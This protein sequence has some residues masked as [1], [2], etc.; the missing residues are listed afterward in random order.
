MSRQDGAMSQIKI[1]KLTPEQE[2]LIPLYSEKWEKIALTTQPIDRQKASETIKEA[3]ALMGLSEPEIL[4]YD[5]PYEALQIIKRKHHQ[6]CPKQWS[7]LSSQLNRQLL[8]KL[9]TDLVSQLG[10][11]LEIQLSIQ[12]RQTFKNLLWMNFYTQLENYLSPQLGSNFLGLAF[13]ESIGSE[14]WA[15][16]AN[17]F[18]F[19]ISGLNCNHSEKDWGL[20]QAIVENTGWTFYYN[21]IAIVCNRPVKL[22]FD[23]EHRLHGIGEP[24]LQY[25]DGFHLYSYH[26]VTLPEKYGKLPPQQWQAQW[27]IEERN[28]EVRR[29]LIQEIGYGRI[30]QEL[31]AKTL[32]SWQEYTLLKIE[33]TDVEPIVLLKM[34]CPSTGFIHALRVPPDVKSAREAIS[35]VNW[36]VDP[37]E[38]SV[39]T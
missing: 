39:Q 15:S 25:A 37:A 19:C 7:S 23:N 32:D 12:I 29:V 4:F 2:A 36:G 11:Q 31:Q 28:A 38:F 5:S 9:Q 3:Y 13:S 33:N 10:N 26:G 16:S 24:A 18:D 14:V 30:C 35:W 1:E 21:K 27:L 20:F 34:T 8:L 17:F 22:S 6:F